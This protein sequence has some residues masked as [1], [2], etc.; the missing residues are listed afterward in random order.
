MGLDEMEA[1]IKGIN[2]DSK[3]EQFIRASQYARSSIDVIPTGSI[4]LDVV[5]RIGGYPRGKLTLIYGEK[6]SGK[7]SLAYVAMKQALEKDPEREVAL[8]DTEG[9]FEIIRLKQL[10]VDLD[11]MWLLEPST[12]EG[13]MNMLEKAIRTG[14]FSLIV[15]DSIAAMPSSKERESD[16]TEYQ[17]AEL[18]RIISK[19]QRKLTTVLRETNT[20]LIFINQL[21]STMNPYG[22]SKTFP[23]GRAL[24]HWSSLIIELIPNDSRR[25]RIVRNNEVVGIEIR[26]RVEKSKLS[27]PLKEVFFDFYFEEGID[28]LKETVDWGANLDIIKQSGNWYKYNDVNMGNGIEKVCEYLRNNP[29]IAREIKKQIYERAGI[30]LVKSAG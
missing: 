2:K 19:A 8:I 11:K 20:A 17:V 5:T 12:A 28:N 7:S 30:V 22:S 4:G 29:E 27:P 24:E 3:E 9:S 15:L 14:K 18:P 10:G 13:A 16:F 1:I 21:R 6:S 25:G 26:A 23:G